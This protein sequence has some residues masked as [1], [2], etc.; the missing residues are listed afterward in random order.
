MSIREFLDLLKGLNCL[1]GRKVHVERLFCSPKFP[2]GFKHIV[3][4][5]CL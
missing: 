4:E 5:V 2:V 1:P 3:I